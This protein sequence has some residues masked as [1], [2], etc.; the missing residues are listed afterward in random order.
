MVTVG[1]TADRGGGRRSKGLGGISLVVSVGLMVVVVVITSLSLVI[2]IMIVLLS[3]S[4]LRTR[5]GGKSGTGSLA[6]P[7]YHVSPNPKVE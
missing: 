7:W 5:L 2:V 6:V 4:G 1:L 3:G